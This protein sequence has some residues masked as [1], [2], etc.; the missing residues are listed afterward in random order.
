MR[1]TTFFRNSML[2]LFALAVSS[3]A[4]ADEFKFKVQNLCSKPVQAAVGWAAPYT[5]VKAPWLAKGWIKIKPGQTKVLYRGKN[6]EVYVHLEQ[7][8]EAD[9]KKFALPDHHLH[10]T[11]FCVM[12]GEKFFAIERIHER[13]GKSEFRIGESRKTL[14]ERAAKCDAAGGKPR[15]G[16]FLMK[17]QHTWVYTCPE[18]PIAP[19]AAATKVPEKTV[20]SV[21]TVVVKQKPRPQPKQQVVMTKSV[22]Y[23]EHE[24]PEP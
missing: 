3:G 23:S 6:E 7:A 14:S 22:S 18:G 24:L 4:T 17:T 20:T 2:I 5:G 16:F 13:S 11:S 12:P 10:Q 19:V 9:Q 1:H 21:E 15:D 8:G